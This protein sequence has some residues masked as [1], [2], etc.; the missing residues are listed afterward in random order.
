MFALPRQSFLPLSHLVILLLALACSTAK[1]TAAP[2]LTASSEWAEQTTQTASYRV[3]VRTGPMVALA[4]MGQEATMT[5]VDQG[6]PVNRHLE[7]YIFDRTSGAEVKTTVP[8]VKI[9]Q[10][11]T[12]LSRGLLNVEACLLANHRITD[13][14]FGDNLYLPDGK[15]TI[16]VSVANESASFEVLL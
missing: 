5:L 14:H 9:S 4:V 11:T 7:V 12:K 2:T 15:Y 6:Q 16:T 8:R 3:K 10:Q 1:P 13:P